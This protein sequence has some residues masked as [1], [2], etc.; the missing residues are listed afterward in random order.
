[1]KRQPDEHPDLSPSTRGASEA[2]S[3][4]RWGFGSFI[5]WE[6]QRRI[7]S[8]GQE[9]KLGSRSFDLLL[10]LLK[11]AGEIV[12]KDELLLAVWGSVVVEETSVRVH[13]SQLRKAL[14]VPGDGEGCREWISNVPLRGY[15]FNGRV[16]RE[17]I[18]PPAKIK[19]K[20][21]ASFTKPPSRLT[22]LV[23]RQT[24]V[25]YVL[26]AIDN[27]RLVTIV[28]P[29][30]IGKT[31]VAL[32]VVER[33]QAKSATEVAFVDLSPLI[34]SEHVL[35]TMARA[36]GGSA[37][38]PDPL[39]AMTQSLAGRNVLVLID[40]CEQV[41]DSLAF[42]ITRLLSALPGLRI[43]ATSRETL[44][45]FGEHVY[46]LPTLAVPSADHFLLA[47]AMQWPSVEL[48]VERAQ[49]AGAGAFD[50][51]D[52]PSLVKISRQLDGI[53]LAIELVAARLGS[54]S[55]NDL[56]SRLNN[57]MR[58]LSIDSRSASAR[59]QSLA[60]ALNWSVDLLSDNELRVFRRLSVFRGHFGAEHALQ[61]VAGEIDPEV[62]FDAL[63]SLVDK[64]LVLFERSE[65]AAP[66]RLLD[67]TRSYAGNL[68]A[69]SDEQAALRQ[70]H[71]S[72]M[73]ALM[74]AA[75]AELP[76]LTELAWGDRYD[77]VLDDVRF[78]LE[79]SLT[80][81]PDAKAAASLVIASAPLWFHLSLV[82]EYRD[83]IAAALKL[84]DEQAEP[85]IETATWLA[86]QL[87]IALLHT[88]GSRSYLNA[89]CDRAL[90]GALATGVRVLELQARWGRCTHD[91]FSGEYAAALPHSET[92][93]ATAES[94]SDPAAL[95]LAHRVSGM[96][97]HFSGRF[98]T[99][100]FHCEASLRLSGPG[101]TRTNMVGVDPVVAA[102]AVL[103]RTLWIRGETTRA[104][105]TA[106]EAVERAEMAGHAAS[107]CSAL[108]GACP[109]ALWSGE[110]EL[111]DRWI[112]KMIGEAQRKGLVT[113]LR[114]AES[115]LQG[116]QLAFDDDPKP[117]VR[118]VFERFS[119]Y[120][121]PRKEMLVTFCADW[122]DDEMAARVEK[123]EGLWCAAETWRA[124]GVRSE[125]RGMAAEAEAFYLR[126]LETCARQRAIG[127]ELRAAPNLA[128]LWA[129]MGRRK[130]AIQLLDDALGKV[131][132]DGHDR[133]AAKA[134]D[135][136]EKIAQELI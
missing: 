114:Y 15:R 40:N 134:R 130:Q 117:H 126:A 3:E 59:H 111:A 50:E 94:W 100:I 70:R 125:R 101:R 132:F 2:S 123:G 88:A 120:E 65:A 28:G 81:Q 19:A 10:Q 67:T 73:L 95:N 58:L 18:G 129:S 62:A 115:F 55:V 104:L 8:S 57:H 4:M 91:M 46:R 79:I 116:L 44:H 43:L 83:W 31:S 12:S 56:A 64:S 127:W 118:Q 38:L 48:L 122:V 41:I 96:A 22:E 97:N 63:V 98:D 60:A 52:G 105:K 24:D 121:S 66:Y 92:L 133:A 25:D 7:E 33:R 106:A 11:R 109:V 90:A 108:Y 86:T 69:E 80:S 20:S 68:L 76:K 29:G 21:G 119:G 54:Q 87:M 131:A 1:M 30:G 71:G 9:I 78:A 53:P 124:L 77:H 23:G 13:M 39:Q 72:L 135:L 6:G 47:Q 136:R 37:D 26:K 17:L 93:L 32:V 75:T 45:I 27:H 34:S 107:L 16:L 103:S 99:S 61:V 102:K 85:N 84:V 110:F 128:T 42:P 112:H 36:L 5:L 49:A 14:G 82:A 89:V 51:L 74:N 113:W 35:A